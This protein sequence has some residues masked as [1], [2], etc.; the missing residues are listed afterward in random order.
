MLPIIV[1]ASPVTLVVAAL[2]V[3]RLSHLL[4]RDM[5]PWDVFERLRLAT[6]GT[7]VGKLLECPFCNS[8]WIAAPAAAVIVRS[9][10]EWVV[11]WLGL[12]GFVVL[13]VKATEKQEPPVV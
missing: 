3:W 8:V 2:A 12:S 10:A 7:F 11:V 6:Y 13:A 1:T 9:W 4:S 5:G